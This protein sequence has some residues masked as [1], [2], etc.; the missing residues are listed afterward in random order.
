MGLN[1]V[2]F[3]IKEFCTK[4][5]KWNQQYTLQKAAS[6]LTQWVLRQ[7]SLIRLQ[8]VHS[9][10]Y[11]YVH[12]CS[13]PQTLLHYFYM[14]RIAKERIRHGVNYYEIEWTV[15]ATVYQGSFQQYTCRC[16][17]FFFVAGKFDRELNLP[18]WQSGL[19]P[20]N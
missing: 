9:V 10:R 15:D 18:L 2:L 5:L 7:P 17:F 3:Y 1:T 16:C 4:H 14:H 6:L 19:K 12:V 20:S 8:M 11:A 13:N